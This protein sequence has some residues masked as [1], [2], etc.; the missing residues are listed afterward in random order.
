MFVPLLVLV[1]LLTVTL[2]VLLVR[3]AR[4][5]VDA[6]RVPGRL[7]EV[8]ARASAAQAAVLRAVDGLDSGVA[9]GPP[10]AEGPDREAPVE[11]R[12]GRRRVLSLIHI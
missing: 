11:R 3:R 4:L 7:A 9:E 12:P 5:R 1:G 10:S 6:A 2:V 8:E